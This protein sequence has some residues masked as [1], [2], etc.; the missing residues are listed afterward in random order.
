MS[1]WL[2]LLSENIRLKANIP[3][4][5]SLLQ[6]AESGLASHRPS[7]K[8]LKG[9]MKRASVALILQLRDGELGVWMIRRAEHEGDPWSGQMAFP[10]GRMEAED[11]NGLATAR[12]ETEEEIGLRLGTLE[13]CIGKLSELN[14]VN[15]RFR[16]LVISPYVFHLK[17]S[18]NFHP[19]YEVAE[20]VW[21]PL[22]FLLDTDNREEM[23]W[24]RNG[25][26]LTMPCYFYEER[27]IWGLS[28]RMLDELMDVVAG[29]SPER[30]RWPRR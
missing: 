28:L 8:W 24:E 27:R 7:R 10:G 30:R 21:V 15:S 6:M 13:P 18:V 12:R 20:V 4:S 19:N 9:I 2:N 5:I 26:R 3:V 1:Y 17:R 11:E 23:V 22:E 14:A 29:K 16:G 25:I